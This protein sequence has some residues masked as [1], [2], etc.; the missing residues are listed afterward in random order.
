MAWHPSIRCAQLFCITLTRI[1]ANN[2][3]AVQ[4][5][6]VKLLGLL[7]TYMHAYMSVTVTEAYFSTTNMMMMN[8]YWLIFLAIGTN[9]CVMIPQQKRHQQISVVQ[10]AS[11]PLV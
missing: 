6:V 3:R 10:L 5:I 7:G 8:N 1:I 9:K 4:V 11:S 2:V